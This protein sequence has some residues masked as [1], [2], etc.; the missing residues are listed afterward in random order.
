MTTEAQTTRYD[1]AAIEQRWMQRWLDADAFHADPDG[2]GEPFSIVVPPPNVTGALHMGHALN[3]SVQDAIIRARRMQGYNA[4]WLPG[5]DH[6]GIA[7]QSVVEKQLRAEGT[8]RLELGRE[9]FVARV[10]EWKDEYAATIMGQF[11][12]LG[13]SMDYARERFTM[14]EGYAG[15]VLRCFVHL[16]DRGLIYR[17][18]YIVNWDPGS[19]TAI[20]DLEVEQ[21]E[22]TDEMVEV[23]Y[24]VVGSDRVLTVATVRPE[25][26]PADVAVAVNPQDERF[27]DLVGQRVRVPLTGRD[28]PVIADDHVDPAFG[29]GALKVTP[30]HDPNDFEIGRR[31]DLETL[32]AIGYDGRLTEACGEFAGLDADTGRRR[33]IER[34]DELGLLRARREYTH[35]VP[36]SHRSGAR[37]EPLVSLQWFC[38][39]QELARPAIEAAEQGEVRFIPDGASR[40]F[41]DW[42]HNIRPWCLSRQLWWGHQLPVWYRGDEV[43]VSVDGPPAAE[44]HEWTRDE[45]V[46]DTWFSS[47]LWSFATWGWPEDTAS[48]Q[49]FHPTAVLSTA[50]DIINLWV[51]RMMM[52]AYEFV[53]EKPFSDVYVHSVVQAPDGRRMSKS[54]GTGIDP[55]DMADAHGADATRYG[56]LAM[57]STQDVRFNEGKLREGRDLAN[58][59]W[60]AVRLVQL[61][62]HPETLAGVDATTVPPLPPSAPLEDAWIVERT[63]QVAADLGGLLDRYDFAL[64]VRELYA[65]TWSELCDWYLEAVKRRLR[66]E[67]PAEA[68]G[69]TAVLGWVLDVVL[70]LAHPIMPHVTEELHHRLWPG[71]DGFLAHASWPGHTA[72]AP[73]GAVARF[74]VVRAATVQ[75]RSL[76]ASAGVAPRDVLR[77]SLVAEGED[78][79]LL[80]EA[81]DLLRDL[82]R[83]ELV[84]DAAGGISVPVGATTMVVAGLDATVLAERLTADLEAARGELALADRKLGNERFVQRAPAELVAAER[85][86]RDQWQARIVELE[87][88]VA[89]IGGS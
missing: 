26:I 75:L 42:M 10:Q 39:M 27:A 21:R 66:S 87:A 88:L 43:H 71:R 23:D 25:T 55:L 62:A 33:I 38:D 63:Q 52:F 51:A 78:A 46:L 31:H 14:D 4:V 22:L 84:D 59:L 77:A 15:A 80:A 89:G 83:I 56:L 8:T 36:H 5:T 30:G 72:P 29:T 48:L 37:V 45:D 1:P 32:S 35:S 41:Y 28:V 65:F 79:A 44:A 64:Y 57:S 60:N 85:A 11:R 16:Y 81:A 69:A 34:L 50:R 7:T 53:G 76:R 24:P 61:D 12:R 67:D 49:R 86:K 58:K 9:A 20:S 18:N 68:A 3:A 73:S 13:A 74:D 70:R 6:A 54:L 17:D 82:A 47:S 19:G 2:P 40:I